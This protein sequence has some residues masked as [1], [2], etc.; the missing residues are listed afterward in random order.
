MDKPV[1]DWRSLEAKIRNGITF[2]DAVS[3]A[4]IPETEAAE[5]LIAR[6]GSKPAV[7]GEIKILA[8]Q[9]L[10]V[11]LK[12]LIKIA[13]EGPRIASRETDAAGGSTGITP[14]S[15]DYD[16]AQALTKFGIDAI[17]LLKQ[18]DT[19]DS[20]PPKV[21][22]AASGGGAFTADLWDLKNPAGG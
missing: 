6:L 12:T 13:E 18:F 7:S 15:S 17:K 8:E 19:T 14:I 22:S 11:G 5:Y 2:A 1:R 16:A 10:K 21:N 9:A 3:Q 20:V 4:G